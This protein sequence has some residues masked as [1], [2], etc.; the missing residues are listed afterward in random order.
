MQSKI[1]TSY[2]FYRFRFAFFQITRMNWRPQRG[3]CYI[4]P[5]YHHTRNSRKRSISRE[6]FVTKLTCCA[7]YLAKKS[8]QLICHSL[9]E[10]MNPKI[11]W[12]FLT[13]RKVLRLFILNTLRFISYSALK[14]MRSTCGKSRHIHMFLAQLWLFCPQHSLSAD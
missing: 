13:F 7:P 12:G 1:L 3:E 10:W 14:L 5:A 6:F 2:S 11:K 9:Y 8:H 4:K